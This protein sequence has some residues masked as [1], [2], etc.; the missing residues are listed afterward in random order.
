MTPTYATNDWRGL[1]HYECDQCEFDTLD[2]DE[3]VQHIRDNHNPPQPKPV[4][5]PKT[6]EV[7]A[8]VVKEEQENA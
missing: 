6:T 8:E 3:M 5:E 1:P 2:E 4:I 7:F